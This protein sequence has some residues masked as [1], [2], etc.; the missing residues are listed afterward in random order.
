MF[1]VRVYGRDRGG[2]LE[3]S[4]EEVAQHLQQL[5]RMYLEMD[6]SFVWVG[7]HSPSIDAPEDGK[8]PEWQLDGM[9]YDAGGMLQYVE[10]RGSCSLSMWQ[11]LLKCLVRCEETT[12]QA[13]LLSIHSVE[14]DHWFDASNFFPEAK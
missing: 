14:D 7:D 5:P 4:F 6:G 9:L 1:F 13:S 11:R 3:V 2:P 12:G 10:L 8:R